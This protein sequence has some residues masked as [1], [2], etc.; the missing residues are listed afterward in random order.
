MRL[1][2]VGPAIS[3]F[4]HRP[5]RLCFGGRKKKKPDSALANPRN[6]YREGR[7]GAR[8]TKAKQTEKRREE[9]RR[10]IG[11]SPLAG[12]T[13]EHR[14]YHQSTAQRQDISLVAA[15]GLL[16]SAPPSPPELRLRPSIPAIGVGLSRDLPGV[17]RAGGGQAWTDPP[18]R[19]WRGRR[20][21]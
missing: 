19:S 5:S 17:R 6:N 11:R 2:Q 1:W 8:T 9:K 13:R 3:S 18:R 12:L 10:E 7:E 14:A 20:G 21:W 16:P 15:G 4:R